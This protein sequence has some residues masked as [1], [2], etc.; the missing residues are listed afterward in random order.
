MVIRETLLQFRGYLLFLF[1]NSVNFSFFFVILSNKIIIPEVSEIPI[2][3]SFFF[4]YYQPQGNGKR[5]QSW[6][7]H[8]V[9][10][11]LKETYFKLS[12]KCVARQKSSQKRMFIKFE[13]AVI[14]LFSRQQ[15]LNFEK[16]SFIPSK[17]KYGLKQ[18]HTHTRT[19]KT[20]IFFY[21]Q[22]NKCMINQVPDQPQ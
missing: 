19:M 5:V 10:W 7:D 4:L 21:A 3:I 6:K 8:L 20:N 9:P 11:K 17:W 15:M 1:S 18:A 16:D 14:P 2:E 12:M 22:M 13:K